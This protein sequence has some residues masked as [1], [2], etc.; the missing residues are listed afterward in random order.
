[1]PQQCSHMQYYGNFMFVLFRVNLSNALSFH[2]C[3]EAMKYLKISH[4]N[5]FTS[6]NMK[7]C[8]QDYGFDSDQKQRSREKND[9]TQNSIHFFWDRSPYTKSNSM[10]FIILSPIQM[11]IK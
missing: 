2:L 9:L 1:M 5:I 10:K 6:I 8:P 3:N 7:T 4:I 11:K